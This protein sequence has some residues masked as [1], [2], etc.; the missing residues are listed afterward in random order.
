MKA[1]LD[2]MLAREGRAKLAQGFFDCL[3]FRVDADLAGWDN[4]DIF[5]HR[6]VA[7]N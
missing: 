5:A 7:K 1:K 6:P 2:E 3:P 4:I